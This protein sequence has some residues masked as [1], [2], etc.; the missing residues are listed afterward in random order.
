MPGGNGLQEEEIGRFRIPFLF[1][2][3]PFY[4][5]GALKSERFFLDLQSIVGYPILMSPTK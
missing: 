5:P 3:D 4:F 2:H 1:L